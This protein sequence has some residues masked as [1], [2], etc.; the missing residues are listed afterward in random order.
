VKTLGEIPAPAASPLRPGTLRR[1]DQQAFERLLAQL[2]GVGVAM[3]TGERQ[4]KRAASAGLASAAAASGRRT[5]LLEC[6]LAE[7]TLAG[8]LGVA[9]APG[10]REYLRDEVEATRILRS[11]V[12]A[13]PG[14]ASAREPLVCVV[15]GRRDEDGEALLASDGFRQA[16]AGLRDAHELVVVEGPPSSAAPGALL[17]AAG[18]ADATLLCLGSG[19]DVPALPVELAGVI[20]QL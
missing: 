9:V 5:A 3:V 11:L 8:D 13:G 15:A 18:R 4:H 1:S 16:I 14:L 2:N 19:E 12:L 6:D 17:A 20:R 7:P 10:L